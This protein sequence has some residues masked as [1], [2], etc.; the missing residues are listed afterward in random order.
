MVLAVYVMNHLLLQ[1]LID[2]TGYSSL[3]T[4]CMYRF[5]S[6][7]RAG[8]PYDSPHLTACHCPPLPATACRCPPLPVTACHGTSALALKRDA[9]GAY[10][11]E[12]APHAHGRPLS[13]LPPTSPFI[14]SNQQTMTG[15][16]SNK[17][18]ASPPSISHH[19]QHIHHRHHHHPG[20]ML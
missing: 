4:S 8:N 17:L 16:I 3:T 1:V 2:L 6:Q 12:G 5:Q 9:C 18:R 7:G 15:T 10:G 19:P 11:D 20:D 14:T 13:T